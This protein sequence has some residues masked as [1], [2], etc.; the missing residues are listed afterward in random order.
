MSPN[1]A[2]F[3]CPECGE[4]T[5]WIHWDA[6]DFKKERHINSVACC[7]KCSKKWAREIWEITSQPAV[8]LNEKADPFGLPEVSYD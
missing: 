6:H 1:D 2:S 8:E 5:V 3:S 4:A 7:V